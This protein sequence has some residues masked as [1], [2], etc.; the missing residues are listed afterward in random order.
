MTKAIAAAMKAIR[1]SLGGAIARS[2]S[3]KLGCS[4]DVREMIEMSAVL[5]AY[6]ALVAER[7]S[8]DR[9]VSLDAARYEKKE[10]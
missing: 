2:P 10:K 5:R 4:D 7:C 9:C 8:L 1:V 3:E 6:N